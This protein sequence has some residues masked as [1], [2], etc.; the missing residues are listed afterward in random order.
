QMA[1]VLNEADIQSVP[2]D[3]DQ[4]LSCPTELAGP[5]AA[6]AGGVQLL[7]DGFLGGRL[8]PKDQIR[9]IRINNNPF[10]TEYSRSGF[11]RIEIITK[12]GTGK[13]RGNFNFN[14]RNDALNATQF[15]S[16]TKLP[17]S[18]QNFQA[19]ISGPLVHNKLTM[20]LSAQR[21][22]SFN[23]T[24]IHALTANGLFQSSITQPNLRENFSSR[25]QYGIN[26]KNMMNF[27]LE[28]ATN[29]RTNQGV[30]QFSLPERAANSN[31]KQWGL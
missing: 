27:N 9:E 18:R 24:N 15:N 16:P 30:G 20:N 4:L 11:G 1:L 23:T 3:E 26:D 5:R 14:L 7:V 28:Y 21:N 25:G 31:G 19:N 8:P 29:S 10:T 2:D 12:P 6:A 17:Y 13:M 22:D